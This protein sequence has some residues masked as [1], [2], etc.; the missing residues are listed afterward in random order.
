MNLKDFPGG[1]AIFVDANIFV[2]HLTGSEGIREECRDFLRR[3]EN[4]EIQAL[5]A[6]FVL[7]EVIYSLLITKGSELSQST[8]IK[9]IQKRIKEEEKFATACYK[10]AEIFLEYIEALKAIGL[11]LVEVG[12]ELQRSSI[13][14]GRDHLLLPRDAIYVKIFQD[15]GIVDIAT[16]DPDLKRVS[17]LTVWSPGDKPS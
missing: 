1:R 6:N 12:Y 17:A 15:V 7:D 9:T 2:L 16:A 10:E 14:V 13:G 3:I 11:T 8:K 4:G 5:T